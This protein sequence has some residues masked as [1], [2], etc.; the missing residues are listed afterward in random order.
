VIEDPPDV[1]VWEGSAASGWRWVW[2]LVL[3]FTVVGAGLLLTAWGRAPWSVPAGVGAVGLTALWGSL[4]FLP[5]LRQRPCGVTVDFP[6]RTLVLRGV[7]VRR[8]L[9]LRGHARLEL[10]FAD[11]RWADDLVDLRRGGRPMRPAV[12]FLGTTAG[13]VS[14]VSSDAR[15]GAVVSAALRE[16][17]D[18]NIS[19]PVL[20][21][22]RLTAAAFLLGLAVLAVA[23]FAS[24]TAG[25]W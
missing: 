13:E 1:V 8:G 14:I 10:R 24:L 12:V 4:G 2:G 15:F 19:P 6:Q 17:R 25:E 18:R 22:T 11:V 3:A 5:I 7:V 9:R 16:A 20:T 21:P 23:A